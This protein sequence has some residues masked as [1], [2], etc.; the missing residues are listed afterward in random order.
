MKNLVPLAFILFCLIQYLFAE[1]ITKQNWISHPKIKEIRLL[2]K[3]I[4]EKA[5]WSEYTKKSKQCELH[6]GAVIISGEFHTD[7]NGIIRLYKIDGGTGDSTSQAEYYYSDKGKLRF[8]F[9]VRKSFNG[10]HSETRT[11]FDK[12]GNEL[13]SDYRLLKKPEYSKV[14]SKSQNNPEAHYNGLCIEN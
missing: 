4:N 9:L 12:L 7:S 8:S 2:F 6:K 3:Q 10:H 13:Y 5:Y 1:P 14:F 11:Y